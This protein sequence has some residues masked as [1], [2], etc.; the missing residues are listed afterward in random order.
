M[1]RRRLLLTVLAGLI[2]VLTA[3]SIGPKYQKPALQVP[4]AYK[5]APAPGAQ[6]MSGWKVA[7]PR[8]DAPRGQWWEIFQDAA[9]NALAEQVNVSNQTIAAAEARLRS[10]H[11]AIRV[12]HAALFPTVTGGAEIMGF[13]QSTNRAPGGNSSGDSRA[14]YLLPL[15]GSYDP[16]LWRRNRLNVDANR[17]NAQASAADLE[18]VRLSLHAEL[19][20]SYFT[21]RGLD[22][23][24]QLLDL[25]IDAFERALEL[26][27]NRY[28]QGV[29]SRVEVEQARTQLEG[30]RAQAI[31]LGVQRARLEHAIAVLIG[32]PP[33]EITIPPASMTAQ[34]PAIPSDLP[35]ELLERRPDIAAAERRVAAANAQIGVTQAAFFPAMTL[36]A[37]IGVN[38][39][40]VLNLFSWPSFLWSVGS[41]LTQ[42]VFDGGRRKALTAAA[43]ADYDATVAAYRQTVL[44]AFQDVEDNLAALRILEAEAQQQENVVKTAETALILAINRYK[45]GVTTYL[46]VIIA[47]S[48][49]LTAK[50]TAVEITTRRM[51][52]AVLLIQALGGGWQGLSM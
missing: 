23:Q 45:G 46:E 43:Q 51:A 40:S 4:S 28:N 2:L 18:T 37:G 22:G 12:A 39:S 50:R 19:A 8:D 36:S 26:T 29:A 47:Q 20:V 16:D 49:A 32:K 27:L 44:N 3:C 11:A 24:K 13:R 6:P 35:S 38:S 5:E 48:A 9:L 14:N 25:T 31:D 10:A 1:P 7:Q 30:T 17:A 52:A 33:A 21:L 41:T 34:P 42:V 15:D